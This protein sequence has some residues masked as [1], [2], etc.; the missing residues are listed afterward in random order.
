MKNTIDD[1]FLF[2]EAERE[3]P[4]LWTESSSNGMV[5]SAHYRATEVGSQILTKGGNAFDAAIAVSVALGVVEPAGSGLGGM[6]MMMMY[7]ARQNKTLFLQGACPAPGNATP[8]LVAASSRTIGYSAVAVPTNPAVLDYA[9]KH[10]GTLP[11]S[12]ILNPVYELA[13]NRFPITSMQANNLAKNLKNIQ[14]GNAASFLLSLKKVIPVPGEFV[15]RPVLAKTIRQLS[16]KGF[17]DFYHGEIGQKILHDMQ[18]HGGFIS[19]KDFEEIPSPQI[20]RPLEGTFFNWILKTPPPPC[21][22]LVLL[23]MMNLFEQLAPPDF[24]PDSPQAALLFTEIIKKSRQDRREFRFIPFN[25]EEWNGPNLAGKQYAAN[26]ASQIKSDISEGETTH[27]NVTD[28]NGN[29]VAVTQSIERSFGAKVAT[30]ELGFLYNGFIKGFKIEND[31]HPHYLKPG[32]V[33]R[34]NAIP[35]IVFQDGK[36]KYAIGSTGSERMASG[37]FQVLVRLYKGQSPFEAVK[38]PRLHCNPEGQVFMEEERFSGE[39]VEFLRKNG[40]EIT[41]YSSPWSFAA[42][43]LHLIVIEGAKHFGIA[44]PRRD[45]AAIGI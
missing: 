10:F 38:A 5:V 4:K 21:G 41:P 34:S 25:L 29:I 2:R 36:P 19:K 9:L 30:P 26:I 32:A 33:A 31:R 13:E 39:A 35:T 37:V 15:K 20:K 28:K 1:R 8:K 14:K 43:G 18:T 12:D 6:T 11:L 44:E 17:E 42:G 23:E 45:G 3:N 22:G 24:D 27:F 7:I 40:Y 16:E